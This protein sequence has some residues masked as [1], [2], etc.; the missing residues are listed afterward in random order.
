M[1]VKKLAKKVLVVL[2]AT[3]VICVVGTVLSLLFIGF[4]TMR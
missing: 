1:Q 4:V 2:A 3:T